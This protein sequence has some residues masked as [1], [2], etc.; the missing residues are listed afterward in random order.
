M[1]SWIV[2]I[3]WAAT[4]SSCGSAPAAQR[5]WAADS[6]RA[7][8]SKPAP[9]ATTGPTVRVPGAV[10]SVEGGGEAPPAE[11]LRLQAWIEHAGRWIA[12]Y[13]GGRFPVPNLDITIVWDTEPGVGFGQHW[14][15]QW[16]KIW[17]GRGTTDTEFDDDWVLVHEMLHACF[18]DLDEKHRWMQEGLSTYLEPIVRVRAKNMTETTMWAKWVER[19]PLGR[20][21]SGDRGLD[22][23]HTW[24]RTY[25]GGALF[26]LMVD[27]ELRR[28]THNRATLRQALQGIVAK[29]GTGRVDWSTAKVVELGDAATKTTVFSDLYGSMAEAPGDVELD[30]LWTDLGVVQKPGGRVELDDTA[31]LAYVRRGITRD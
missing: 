13:Y 29:G 18:P 28:R 7:P 10:F 15:G 3:G 19:M 9:A 12:D 11:L 4:L 23:T 17:V 6:R 5:P 21:R 25:W 27:V 16:L 24:A 30:P 20:P 2:A 26:W 22:Q 14:N 8:K 1:H 31:P